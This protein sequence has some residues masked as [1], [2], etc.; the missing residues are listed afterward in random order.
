MITIIGNGIILYHDI[1]NILYILYYIIIIIIYIYIYII[2]TL[3]AS[4]ADSTD[5]SFEIND[6]STS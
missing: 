2:I 3:I 4:N 6:T 5:F 1:Y